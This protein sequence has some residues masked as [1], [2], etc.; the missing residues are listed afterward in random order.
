MAQTYTELHFRVLAYDEIMKLI[1]LG[2]INALKP[3]SVAKIYKDI[4]K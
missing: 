3:C 4:S 2:T 1:V